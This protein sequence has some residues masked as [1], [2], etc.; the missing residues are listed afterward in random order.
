M[1]E[2]AQIK[3][4]ERRAR[5]LSKPRDKS[6]YLAVELVLVRK[7]KLRPRNGPLWRKVSDAARLKIRTQMMEENELGTLR[8]AASRRQGRCSTT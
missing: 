4:R 7:S 5:E 8:R 3:I 1:V 6:I 2:A